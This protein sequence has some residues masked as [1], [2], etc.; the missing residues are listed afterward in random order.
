MHLIYPNSNDFVPNLL[1]LI[2]KD[3]YKIVELS[4]FNI[5]D[6]QVNINKYRINYNKDTQVLKI[7]T[8]NK[9]RNPKNFN[10]FIDTFIETKFIL[11]KDLSPGQFKVKE[12]HPYPSY[13]EESTRKL[14]L[15]SLI[16]QQGELIVTQKPFMEPIFGR[17]FVVQSYNRIYKV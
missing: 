12:I 11:N 5:L 14:L 10:L 17:G 1:K 4:Q 8:G 9:I 3:R 7:K 2:E 15:V 16:S 6:I 13:I